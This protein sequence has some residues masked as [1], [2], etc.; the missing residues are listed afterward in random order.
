MRLLHRI[1]DSAVVIARELR[2]PN[3]TD[4]DHPILYRYSLLVYKVP[5]ENGYMLSTQTVSL[6]AASD[7]EQSL[8]QHLLRQSGL[9][10]VTM[11]GMVFTHLVDPETGSRAGCRVQLAGRTSDGSLSYAHKVL[12]ESLPAVLRWED[13]CV[14]PIL[15]LDTS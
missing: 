15:C 2:L 12:I 5:I 11:Y 10:L 3:S 1:G 8:S 9:P 4:P 6:E 7:V 13:T 14:A